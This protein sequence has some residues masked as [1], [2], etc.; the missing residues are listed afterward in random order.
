MNKIRVLLAD[1]HQIMLDGLNLVLQDKEHIQ[2]VASVNDGEEVLEFLRENRDAVDIAVLDVEMPKMNGIEATKKI[3][4]HYP[5]IRV[6]I[7][8]M[9]KNEGFITQLAR[10]GASGYILKLQGRSEL[11][12]AIETIYAGEEYYDRK[13]AKILL[14]GVK[15]PQ[16]G[17]VKLTNREIEILKLIAQGFTTPQISNKLHIAEST[18]N[19]H[20]RN[21]IEK[22]GV[23]NVNGLVRYAIENGYE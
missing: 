21:L 12:E 1:D 4:E 8:T 2:I 15:N 23:S 7:L 22:L 19:T 9:H 17:N 18:V 10:S 11:V 3:K 13:V 14:E 16:I 5:N 20:R 6:L